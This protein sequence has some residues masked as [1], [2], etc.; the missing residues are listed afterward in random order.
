MRKMIRST[1]ITS[2][3]GVVLISDMGVSPPP[4]EI[5]IVNSL[6]AQKLSVTLKS[7]GIVSRRS[8]PLRSEAVGAGGDADGVSRPPEQTYFLAAAGFA[9][10]GLAAGAAVTAGFTAPSELM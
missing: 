3:K 6:S 10:A 5:A 8:T 2:T 9:A 1:S 7:R 4:I